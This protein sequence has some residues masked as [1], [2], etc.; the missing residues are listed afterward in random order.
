MRLAEIPY[1]F[2]DGCLVHVKDV[3]RGKSCACT[4]PACSSPLIA[5]QGA[6]KAWHF[7]HATSQC[8]DYGETIAHLLTKELLDHERRLFLPG[9]KCGEYQAE[10]K[11]WHIDEIKIECKLNDIR[12]DILAR[13]GGK[14]ILIEVFV[15]H[16]VDEEKR[17]SIEK[18]QMSCLEI[19][20]D[21]TMERENILAAILSGANSHWVWNQRLEILR[22]AHKE[23]LKEQRALKAEED[24]RKKRELSRRQELH[25]QQEHRRQE[26]WR[27]KL[28]LPGDVVLRSVKTKRMKIDRDGFVSTEFVALDATKRRFPVQ[29]FKRLDFRSAGDAPI[30]L[31]G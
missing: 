30:T 1:G 20:I 8:E 11:I 10:G 17:K 12:P 31:D 25:K 26:F 16:K 29:S 9:I 6:Q 7:A 21:P 18:L 27:D 22:A 4:C 3:M 14:W 28:G 23:K 19:R 5:R 2:K 15:N 13:I 24:D